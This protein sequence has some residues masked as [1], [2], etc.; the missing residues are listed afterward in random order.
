[1]QAQ[2]LWEISVATAPEAEE[3]VHELLQRVFKAEPFVYR[4]EASGAILVTV[5]SPQQERPRRK[6]S[7]GLSAGLKFIEQCGLNVS[8][9]KVRIKQLKPQ[10]WAEAWKCHF[11]PITIGR[12]LLLTPSWSQRRARKG[13][14]VVVLDPGLSFG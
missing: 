9:N 6:Q 14:A 2:A 11:K 4:E 13:Q 8:P 3:A 5:H 10:D 12:T 7:V 1:M